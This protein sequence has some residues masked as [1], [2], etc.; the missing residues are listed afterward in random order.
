MVAGRLGDGSR[1]WHHVELIDEAMSLFLCPRSAEDE[2]VADRFARRLL[3]LVVQ[4]CRHV[5]ESCRP[6]QLDALIT[7]AF[8]ARQSMFCGNSSSQATAAWTSLARLL[9]SVPAAHLL[10]VLEV[11]FCLNTAPR[12]HN[13]RR[14]PDLGDF[15]VCYGANEPNSTIVYHHTPSVA[16]VD[17][18][19][20]SFDRLVA[21]LLRQAQSRTRGVGGTR[22]RPLLVTVCR[23]VRDGYTP[24][25]LAA[26]IE[27]GILSALRRQRRSGTMTVIYDNDLLAGRGG[28]DNRPY[29]TNPVSTEKET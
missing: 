20:R 29:S 21:E 18:Q 6:P 27:A 9:A 22:R 7:S 16:E 4:V 23:S 14:E 25:A 12:T 19:M 13:F 28:W 15:I 26:H 2:S 17:V 3:R 24:R 11:G 1:S 10:A 8:L 5:T